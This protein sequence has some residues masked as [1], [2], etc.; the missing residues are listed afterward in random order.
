MRATMVNGLCEGKQP[1]MNLLGPVIVMLLATSEQ[2][3][4]ELGSERAVPD[5]RAVHIEHGVEQVL[6]VAGHDLQVRELAAD[7]GQLG[8]PACLL[9]TSP[10]PRDGLL[11]RMP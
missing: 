1:I 7:H 3:D 11:S 5:E 2:L 4:H 8:I 9:Y 6:V 10:S